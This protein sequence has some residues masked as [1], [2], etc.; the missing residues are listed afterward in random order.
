MSPILPSLKGEGSIFVRNAALKN[1]KLMSAVSKATQKD[2]LNDATVK[3]IEIKTKID[4]NIITLERTKIKF[5]G[6]RPRFEGQVSMDGALNLKARLGLPPFGI[7]GIPLT[8]TGTSE[9]PIV[10]V[11][12]GKNGVMLEE[13]ADEDDVEEMLKATQS[14]DSLA[15]PKP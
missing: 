11:R 2:S 15:S 3:D 1:F 4:N 12:R 9:A 8:V 10:K 13:T 7:L 6:F 14:L 5:L